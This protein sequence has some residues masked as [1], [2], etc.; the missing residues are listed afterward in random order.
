MRFDIGEIYA[1][2]FSMPVIYLPDWCGLIPG[3]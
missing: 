1:Q 2:A 3:V